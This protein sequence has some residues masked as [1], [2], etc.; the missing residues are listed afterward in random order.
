[1]IGLLITCEGPDGSGKT[2][3][4]RKLGE[5]L[6]NR[7]YPVVMTR[8]P[9]GTPISDKIRTIILD[10][11]NKTMADAT[12]VLLY[13]ASRAQHVE[14]TIRPALAAGKVVLCDRF[15]DASIAYQG[16]GLGIAR[17]QVEAINRFATGGLQPTRSYLLD[18][19]VTVSL[20]RLS[21]RALASATAPLDRIERKKAAYHQRVR[22]GFHTLAADH[23]ERIVLIDANRTEEAI[24]G[25]ILADCLNLL[26]ERV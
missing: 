12:E 1:M 14:E 7:G 4:L 22:D 16:F 8:E 2:T 23:P 11:E 6:Q 19:P 3:Q 21:D 25:D 10:P 26:E 9:G 18:V 13:A 17:E 20:Q 15:V 24:F 5:E